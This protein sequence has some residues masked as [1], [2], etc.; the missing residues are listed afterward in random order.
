MSTTSPVPSAPAAR[1][2]RPSD[3]LARKRRGQPF[4]ML[5]AYDATTAG[6]LERAGIDVLLVG[7]SVG[8]NV[9]GHPSTVPVTLDAMVHHTAAVVRG[10]HSAL[11]VADL[12]FGSY[13]V[14]VAQGVASAIR[15]L[16]AGGAQAVKAEGAGPVV[17]LCARLVSAGIPFMG[18]LG[19][20][21]QS[22]H[23]TGY[24]VQGR[25]A[26]AADR[27]AADAEAL[28]DAGAFAVVLEAVPADLGARITKAIDAVTVGIGAG[29][30][31][32]GQVLV[33]HD[34]LGLSPRA[35]SFARRYADLAGT[36]TAAAAAYAE[37]VRTGGFPTLEE[38]F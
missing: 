19:L 25:D 29:G 4:P 37:D 32:D 36:I 11:I 24:A 1:R 38:S 34:V 14:D 22:V 15:L 33:T 16:Q 28:A 27:L 12:P 17:D 3:L 31:T 21:P 9:L 2:T 10:T 7:D 6:L 23:Q 5:T 20:T 18:H 8:D 26:E 30:D 35:P 13:Q